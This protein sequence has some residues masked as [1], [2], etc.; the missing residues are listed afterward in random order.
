[1]LMS[2]LPA[3]CFFIEG[4][5]LCLYCRNEWHIEHCTYTAFSV[6]LLNTFKR[7]YISLLKTLFLSAKIRC[8]NLALTHRNRHQHLWLILSKYSLQNRS[9]SSVKWTWGDNSEHTS[10]WGEK[11]CNFESIYLVRKIKART[12]RDLILPN[13]ILPD[14][15]N[16]AR[17]PDPTLVL[18]RSYH[19]KLPYA[20][21]KL[22]MH[23][24][25]FKEV[26]TLFH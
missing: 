8:W 24:N 25:G 21:D 11:P 10:S 12:T 5:E 15:S 22:N 17:K 9:K 4:V 18:P 26:H 19:T 2:C 23:H 20:L 3:I 13:C 6:A 1:M 7:H 14:L 16:S